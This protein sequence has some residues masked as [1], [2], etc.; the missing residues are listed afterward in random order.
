M[1]R[2]KRKGA[3]EARNQFSDLLAAAEN[4]DSTIITKHGRPVAVVIPA[5]QYQ[6][7]RR[8][9][10]ILPLRGSGRGM[11]GGDSSKTIAALRDEWER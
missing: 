6:G 8:Q 2:V 10:S 1:G 7:S 9:R 5:E 4:G 3:E 11:W